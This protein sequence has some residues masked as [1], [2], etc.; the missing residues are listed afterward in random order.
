MLNILKYFEE[1]H[2]IQS[3]L[4]TTDVTSHFLKLCICQLPEVTEIGLI[5]QTVALISSSSLTAL[6]HLQHHRPL[7]RPPAPPVTS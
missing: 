6:R 2:V 5:A 7:L 3:T 4:G 1:P